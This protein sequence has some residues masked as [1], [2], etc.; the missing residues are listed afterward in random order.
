[1]DLLL[2]WLFL[3]STPSAFLA[4]IAYFFALSEFRQAV[5]RDQPAAWEAA[6]AQRRMIVRPS[7][8]IAYQLLGDSAG[9][10]LEG[11]PLTEGIRR[12][13][14]SASFRQYTGTALFLVFL[15]SALLRD[16]IHG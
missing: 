4:T 3:I 2:T 7:F 16:A 15:L 11:T 5:I 9:G 1:M 13:R 14:R 6:M 8:Q 12:A 10:A